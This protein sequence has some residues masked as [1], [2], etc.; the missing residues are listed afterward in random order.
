LVTSSR[1]HGLMGDSFFYAGALVFN[2]TVLQGYNFSAIA[3]DASIFVEASLPDTIP[4]PA[5][6]SPELSELLNGT[7]ISPDSLPPKLAQL[8]NGTTIPPEFAQYLNGSTTPTDLAQYLNGTSILSNLTQYLNATAAQ[9]ALLNITN[10]VGVNTLGSVNKSAVIE[11]LQRLRAGADQG[12][13]VHV[14]LTVMHNTS[15]DHALPA[16]IAELAQARLRGKTLR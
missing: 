2:D 11:A 10:P 4:V 7:S 6:L 1:G 12:M 14:P 8:L 16:L 13:G 15:S 5:S 9:S 3:G